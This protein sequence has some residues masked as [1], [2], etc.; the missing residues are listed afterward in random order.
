MQETTFAPQAPTRYTLPAPHRPLSDTPIYDALE[1][2]WRREG[3]TLPRQTAP[4]GWE[5][6]YDR[7]EDRFHRG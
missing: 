6:A 2:E 5:G 3:R 4:T 1:R 7:G